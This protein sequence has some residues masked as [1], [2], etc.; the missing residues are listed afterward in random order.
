M[1]TYQE[2]AASSE[3][4]PFIVAHRG[5]WGPAPENS[6]RS[7]ETAVA[8]GYDV[9]EIDVRLSAD[10]IPMAFHD[11][12][13]DRMTGHAGRPGQMTAAGLAALKQRAGRGGPDSPVTDMGI[14]T[15]S[16]VLEAARGRMCLDIDVKDAH[17]RDAVRSV[18]ADMGMGSQVDVKLFYRLGDDAE[19]ALAR[20]DAA[21]IGRMLIARFEAGN[22]RAMLRSVLELRPF[23]VETE[24]DTYDRLVTVARILRD[25]GIALWVNTLDA[26][27]SAGLSDSQAVADPHAVWGA[28][29]DAGVSFIQTDRPD[30]VAQFRAFRQNAMSMP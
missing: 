20:D 29:V 6:T 21:G 5:A 24:F 13:L 19:P 30:A 16:Q 28:L 27:H 26:V 4:R 10:G 12:T 8:A 11:D 18:V 25:D 22:W 15:L 3:G 17:A 14:Q 9:A 1:K 23:L 7:I 2:L